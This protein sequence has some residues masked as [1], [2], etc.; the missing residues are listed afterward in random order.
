MTM[1]LFNNSP[2]R[3]KGIGILQLRLFIGVRLIYGV[4]DNVLN[5]D[6][7]LQFRDFLKL[8]NIPLPLTCAVTSVY[9]QLIAGVMFIL[10]WKI[11]IAALLII[12]N[13][14]IAI[15]VVHANDSFEQMTAPLAILVSS[16]LFLFE[17]AG[18]YSIE[19]EVVK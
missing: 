5:W 12:F 9:V 3:S 16:L 18:R 11:R 4:M 17:R 2:G 1:N 19:K 7:M 14:I 13:F 8:F 6:H 10:G 15:V